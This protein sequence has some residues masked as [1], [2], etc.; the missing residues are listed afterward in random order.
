MYLRKKSKQRS[1]VSLDEPL[2]SDSDGN[3][4]HL[5]DVIGTDN[6]RAINELANYRDDY[7][8]HSV[9]YWKKA[10]DSMELSDDE[11]YQQMMAVYNLLEDMKDYITGAKRL[12]REKM[13]DMIDEMQNQLENY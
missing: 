9:S 1:E 11:K 3:E 10:Y 8:T 2:K 12:N 4:L 13:L 5:E 6:V 7:D